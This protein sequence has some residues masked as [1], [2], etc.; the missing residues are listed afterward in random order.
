[1][2][3]NGYKIMFDIFYVRIFSVLRDAGFRVEDGLRKG[4]VE[5]QNL[6]ARGDRG[7]SVK[8]IRFQ[9]VGPEKCAL[10]KNAKPGRL[11]RK[12]EKNQ[13]FRPAKAAKS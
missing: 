1:M 8:S 11:I 7:K 2:H 5:M 6:L 13:P 3:A 4:F 10:C 12:S 9:L